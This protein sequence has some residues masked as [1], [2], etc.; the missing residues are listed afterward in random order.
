LLKFPAIIIGVLTACIALSHSGCAEPEWPAGLPHGEI[1]LPN[2]SDPDTPGA[3][4]D[5]SEGQ[6]VYGEDGIARG[7]IYLD[8]TFICGNAKLDVA[9]HETQTDTIL[10]DSTAP[11]WGSGWVEPNNED[12]PARVP[13]NNHMNIWVRTAEGHF[14]KLRIL[15]KEA[16]TDYSSF[17]RVKFE[18]I[19]QPDGSNELH[20]LTDSSD[21]AGIN[22]TT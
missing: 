7:D 2:I 1:I 22:D 11:G 17:L 4:F 10:Y 6:I 19:Y 12:S 15:M 20:P 16:N 3:Y 8:H 13:V 9:L 18:W 21:Q 5:I 14:G